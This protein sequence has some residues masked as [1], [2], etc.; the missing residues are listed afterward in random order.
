MAKVYHETE[1][2]ELF[3]L[4]TDVHRPIAVH[5]PSALAKL[6]YFVAVRVRASAAG[7]LD[8]VKTTLRVASRQ[9]TEETLS[10]GQGLAGPSTIASKVRGWV[11]R[12]LC[13]PMA[14]RGDG[15]LTFHG[16]PRCVRKA[17]V[18]LCTW[19]RFVESGQAD[20]YIDGQGDPT[21]APGGVPLGG[22]G[23]GK[24]EICRDG[25]FR[26]FSANNNQDMPLENPA[27]LEGAYL[28]VAAGRTQRVLATSAVDG[29]PPCRV[30]RAEP[31][32]PQM[33]LAAP[34][35]LPGI[36]VE[37]LLS[38]PIIPHDLKTS[39]L[40]GF[41]VRW[42]IRNRSRRPRVVRCR[43]A[44]PNL[45]GVGGGIGEPER[46]IGYADGYYRYWDAPAGQ[47]VRLVEAKG[48]VALAYGNRPCGVS[49]AA[50]GRHFLAVKRD[51]GRA[52]PTPDRNRGSIAYEAT[53][54]PGGVASVHMAVVWEMPHW[55]DTLG[56]DRG[57]YWQNFFRNGTEIVNHLLVNAEAILSGAGRLGKLVRSTRLPA[58]LKRRL[59]NC[60]YPL[61]TNSVFYRD[62]RFSINEGPSE[63]GGCFG[64]LDQRL[65]AHP[66]TQLLFPQLNRRELE[67]FGEYQA[68]DG[69]VNHDLGGGSLERGPAPVGWPDLTCSFVIQNARHAW[70]TG[71]REFEKLA[72]ER[73]R[74]ALLRH[75]IW[76]EA[77][78][79]LA[80]LGDGLG[81]SYDAYQYHGSSPYVGTL[82]IA[83]LLVG[84]KWAGRL[85]DGEM[86]A[87]IDRWLPAALKR[88]EDDL[89]N[90]TYYRAYGAA[91]GHRNENSHA[92]MLAGQWYAR[93]LTGTDVLPDDRLRS[94]AG[95]LLKLNGNRR[96]R[97]PP[98]EATPEGRAGSEFGWLP[99]VECF[100]L[101]ALASLRNKGVLPLWRRM[102]RYMDGG[103]KRPCDTRLMYRPATG[104][105][106]WGAYYMTAPASWLVYDAM[107]DFVYW[108]EEGVL[109]LSPQ[110]SGTFPVMHPLFWAVGRRQG[111][112]TE[113]DV[114]EVFAEGLAVRY[115][116]LPAGATSLRFGNARI[117]A[118]RP[119]GRY[120]RFAIPL[121]QL[122]PGLRL[123]W[124][125]E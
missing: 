102:V 50:D 10:M 86:V 99:Y 84:R 51:S 105:P 43:L 123:T 32:F 40:P 87:R 14:A 95:A 117:K 68:A 112:R 7:K 15:T 121:Q 59:V 96:F 94:C 109:R 90:G 28:S 78:G 120:L 73:S 21:T 113:L 60:C 63:M 2:Q 29:I 82:W 6:G 76:A 118:C 75:G 91:G 80:Q 13:R 9:P 22:I 25:R 54:A 4:Y 69:G 1:H 124:C 53:I 104:E 36:D 122:R 119:S 100:C 107:L 48:F 103:G 18:V 52:I 5:I 49:A 67:E 55:I 38:G 83:A 12:V 79:G 37:V 42:R 88:M 92:G 111:G 8:G 81:T 74:R 23:C 77:G 31:A 58:W 47:R 98:D 19:L 125:V 35:A 26:N 45:V 30:L 16:M 97:I 46:R 27:G 33:R 106:S 11:W 110:F 34:D 57:L 85:G 3:Y 66:A 71:D 56:V 114:R 24:V 72:Y 39:S 93:M 116:E 17:H 65:G 101:A 61:V 115:L 89:W 44:W 62:G 41:L 20:D 64:T 70:S 108:P